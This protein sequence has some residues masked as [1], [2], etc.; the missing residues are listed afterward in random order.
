MTSAIELVDTL[1][2]QARDHGASDIHLEPEAKQIRVRLRLDGLLKDGAP[3]PKTIL[4]QI[5]SRL[6]ILANLPT[7]EHFTA[8][9]GRFRVQHKKG[10]FDVRLSIV[11]THWGENAVIRLLTRG[12][13]SQASLTDLG[14]TEANQSLIKRA[15]SKPQGLILITGPTGSGKTTTLYTLLQMLNRPEASIITIENPIEYAIP[16]VQQIQVNH[17]YGLNFANGLRSMLRQD[18]DIMMVG[19]IR[20]T[21]TARLAMNAAL[22]GHLLLSTVH[23]NNAVATIPRLIDLGI[24]PYLLAATMRLVISQRLV[25]RVEGKELKGRIGIQE[26]LG[27]NSPIREAISNRLPMQEIQELAEGQNM[28]PILTD[29]MVKA[30]RGLTTREEV[31]RAAQPD[32]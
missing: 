25:R 20:D 30:R 19:E 22:T 9:D 32:D 17:K 16:G 27:I 6:K 10:A 11:P 26:V 15:I 31:W 28:V 2:A 23:T 7:D 14:F 5:I 24:E 21:E 18:P 12:R 13:L 3:L 29:G 1:I 4:P 8:H